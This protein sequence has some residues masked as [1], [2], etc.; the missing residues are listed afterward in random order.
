MRGII[1]FEAKKKKALSAEAKIPKY[2]PKVEGTND[3]IS[4]LRTSNFT[5]V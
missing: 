5:A 3:K 1:S 4:H 2:E